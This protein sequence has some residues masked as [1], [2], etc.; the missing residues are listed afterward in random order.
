MGIKKCNVCGV[1]KDTNEFRL[2]KDKKGNYKIYYCCKDCEIILRKEYN[3]K[4]ET[5]QKKHEYK[6]K[7]MVEHKNEISEKN[8]KYYLKPETKQKRKKYLLENKEHIKMVAKEYQC[9]H[10]KELNKKEREKRQTDSLFRLKNIVRKLIGR[11]F[12]YINK[13]KCL[14][15]KEIVGLPIDELEKY[16]LKTYIDN[17]GYEWDRIEKVHID[18]KKPLKYAKTEEEVMELCHY[19]NL[20]LLKAEDNL[21][22]GAKLDWEIG[23]NE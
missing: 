7:Y 15:T 4:P 19:T 23:N 21:K 10:R 8:K 18:H 16:L 9:K 5:K 13:E 12:N 22:K 1:E 2:K 14:K 3:S 20:Q 6:Q 17:Y 11:S